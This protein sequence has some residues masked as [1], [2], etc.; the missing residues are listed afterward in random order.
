MDEDQKPI[1]GAENEQTKQNEDEQSII[2][3]EGAVEEPN[4]T[5]VQKMYD[6]LGIKAKAPSDKPSKRPKADDG[7]DKKTAKQDDASGKSEQK[8]END[9]SKKQSK[10]SSTSDKD[11]VDGNEADEK[12]KKSSKSDGKDGE[13]DGE[14]SKD[15]K[16]DETGVQETKSEDN[17]EAGATGK[18]S[19]EEGDGGSRE[20]SEGGKRPGKSNPAVE[21]RMQELAAQRKEALERA[22][23]AERKLRESTLAQEQAKIAQEDP[24]YTIE[25][26]MKV[27]DEYG[28]IIDLD[29]DQAELAWRRWKD[30]YDQRQE[31]RQAKANYEAS[32]REREEAQTRKL[33]QD[34][35]DAYDTLA[36]LMDEYPELVSTS[37]QYDPDFANKAMPIINEAI[38]YLE[39]TEPGNPE[40]KQPVIVGLRINPKTIL[41]AMKDIREAKR[42]LPL[43]GINDNVDVG[44]NVNVPHSRSS[45]PNI[46]AAN[47]LYKELGINKRI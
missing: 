38:Q 18:D 11:G 31:E 40:G 27:R 10:T 41:S 1:E 45:D 12:S 20:D 32:Q 44:S 43:N 42:N 13:K 4:P 39:G 9:D 2:A 37:G 36:G 47:Q 19:G 21:K 23:E 28:D 33:M 26:F 7:G 8:Q 25:D 24:E 30:G 34:S 6:E 17:E 46:Q 35:A 15:S 3:K 22:E 5:D 14:V 16:Q 29:R